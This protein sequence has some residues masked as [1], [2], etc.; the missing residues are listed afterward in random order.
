[1]HIVM[2]HGYFLKGTGSNLFVHNVCNI[3]CKMGHQVTLFCQ[4]D[5]VADI[6]YIQSAYELSSNN[7]KL[8]LF[9]RKNTPYQGKCTLIKPNTNGFLPVYVFDHYQG[10]VVKELRTCSQEE[11]ENYISCHVAAI[12]TVLNGMPVDMVWANHTI[13]QP[14]YVARSILGNTACQHLMTVHGSC[15]NFAV[16]KSS[17]LQEYARE[18]ISKTDQIVFVSQY[19]KEEFL[20]FFEHDKQIENKSVVI[21]AGVDLNKF[22]PL[23]ANQSKKAE[24]EGLLQEL[25]SQ[26]KASLLHIHEESSWKT[27]ED[28]VE[29]LRD[30]NFDYGK[31]MIYYGKY[32][33]TKGIQFLIAAA[34]I[35]L[36]KYPE[37]RFLLV[38]YG[39]ARP[40]LEAMI[41]TLHKGDREQFSLL[42]QHPEQFDIDIDSNTSMLYEGLLETLKDATFAQ[43]Y[44]S[45][46]QEHLKASML[47]TGYLSHDQLKHLIACSDI[48]IA[49]SVFPEA[50]GLVAI[51]ALSAGII[52][53]QTN[54]SGFSDVIQKYVNEFQDLFDKT[55][56]VPLYLD[57][58]LVLNI[59]NNSCV[60]FRHYENMDETQRQL[61]RQRARSVAAQNYS[62]DAIVHQYISLFK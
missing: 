27:D 15:L 58:N 56:M 36:Q 24:L 32:L 49:P 8:S 50:F 12:D 59:A 10:Y 51:E 25:D 7:K 41:E 47:F 38:G 1:M 43:Q 9:H 17:L 16:R 53:M 34:P 45:V 44:F 5:D 33:W 13:L 18:A 31:T 48:S 20:T 52:P 11:I 22:L 55:K 40:C 37:V 61:V 29:K 35:I 4:E 2:V 54:H 3:L 6:D 57:K 21:P 30:L 39:S 23:P 26:K 60:L 14:V 19:A 46:A 42:L 28:V 62:W